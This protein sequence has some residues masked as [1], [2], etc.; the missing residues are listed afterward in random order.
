MA[1][2]AK[3]DAVIIGSG[4]NGL[5]AAI[6]L[7]RAGRSVLVVEAKDT[8]GGG[9]RTAELTLPGFQHDICSAVHPLAIGAPFFHTLPLDQFGLQ[10]IFPPA[11]LAHPLD[12][13]RVGML[14]RSVEETAAGLGA[15]GPAYIRLMKPLV[16]SWPQI[17]QSLLGPLAL[18]RHPLALGRF[19]LQ[20]L[21]SAEGLAKGVF[22]ED[23][24][25][26]MFGG[27]AGHSMLPLNQS[28]S[29]AFGL[30][31]GMLAHAVGWPVPRGGSQKIADALAGYLKSLGGEIVTG[32]TVTR[33]EELPPAR[34]IMFN[35]TPRQI[36]SLAGSHLPD[37]YRKRLSKFRYGLGAFKLDYALSGP[38]PWKAA[39]CSRAAT[40]HLGGTLEEITANEKAASEGQPPSSPFVLVT[41]PSLFDSSRAPAGQHTLWAYCHVPNGSTFDMT[42]RIENQIERFA[43]GFRSIVLARHVTSPV[44]LENYNANYVG[45]DINGGIQDLRQLFTRPVA[46]LVPYTTPNPKLFICSSSTPPG[47]GVH[48]MSG[49]Y[50]AQAVLHR[51]KNEK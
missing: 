13:G 50:A 20:A 40:V 2:Q 33:I 30:V 28:P 10:W 36:L 23:V 16:E 3:Y 44:D 26:A 7:A 41:Q 25:R 39:G 47:G 27:Q 32:Q 15:D 12:D 42:E 51:F 37:G 43:P 35:N 22:K 1:N 31:L 11:E 29:A 8:V 9:M 17:N 34:A 6:T 5:A 45:G 18:P 21:R 46:R 49:F 48:G 24:A 14:E 4:P 19:G 38:V